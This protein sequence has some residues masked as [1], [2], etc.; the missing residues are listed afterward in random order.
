M[1]E[2]LKTKTNDVLKYMIDYFDYVSYNQKYCFKVCLQKIIVNSCKCYDLKFK[3]RQQRV[4]RGCTT[5]RELE[6]LKNTEKEFYKNAK[7]VDE[8]YNKCNFKTLFI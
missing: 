1:D 8:C 3:L 4:V 2:D 6:C 5:T 7:K